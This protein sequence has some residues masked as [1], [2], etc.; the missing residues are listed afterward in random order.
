LHVVLALAASL[1]ITAGPAVAPIASAPK[2][3]A[4]EPAPRSTVK[5][6]PPRHAEPQPRPDAPRRAPAGTSPSLAAAPPAAANRAPARA[7]A[8]APTPAP[9]GDPANGRAFLEAGL[10]L[11]E[12]K[13]AKCHAL[14]LAI[15]SELSPGQW[16]LHMKRMANRPG[17]AISEDQARLIH[18][19]L[20]AWYAQQ[21]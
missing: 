13:C 15:G 14:S 20:Q 5:P 11:V 4:P 2:L 1:T 8:P 17:A 7:L 10:Q 21:P 18:E 19:F 6:P 12:R 16:K 9:A 3:L